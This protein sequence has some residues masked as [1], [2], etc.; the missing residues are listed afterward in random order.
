MCTQEELERERDKEV[1]SAK[2]SAEFRRGL[3]GIGGH[4]P[5]TARS[6]ASKKLAGPSSKKL[7]PSVPRK[8]SGMTLNSAS[9][10]HSNSSSPN[11]SRGGGGKVTSGKRERERERIISMLNQTSL[12]NQNLPIAITKYNPLSFCNR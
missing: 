7:S 6:L 4:S 8:T 2:L 11:P 12:Q 3:K 5:S 1:L 10:S 9:S